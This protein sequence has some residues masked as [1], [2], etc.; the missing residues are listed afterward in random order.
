MAPIRL[1]ERP[2]SMPSRWH[3]VAP[4][5][6]VARDVYI[7]GPQA[8]DFV[9][10]SARG[11]DLVEVQDLA[12]LRRFL[13]DEEQRLVDDGLLHA[14][15]HEVE[16]FAAADALDRRVDGLAHLRLGPGAGGLFGGHG[17]SLQRSRC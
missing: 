13:H 7:F 14:A 17:Q 16:G 11:D 5:G 15:T 9:G 3:G 12:E 2:Q 1:A 4:A 8:R 6:T 10:D